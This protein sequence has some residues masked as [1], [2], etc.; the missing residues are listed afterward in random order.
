[1]SEQTAQEPTMEEILASIRRIIS[2]D[3]APAA[4]AA[5]AH[6]PEPEHAPEPEH[7]HAPAEVAPSMM[8]ETPSMEE[9]D[10]LELT[11]RWEEPA[12]VETI[13]DIE[14]APRPFEAPRPEPVYE[15]PRAPLR[16]EP[17]ADSLVSNHIADSAASSFAGLAQQIMMPRNGLM[18]ED[19][20]KEMMKPLLKQWL[21]Q[22]LDRIVQEAVRVEVERISR[23]GA[24]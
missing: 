11:D 18:L 15:A 8:D 14:A 3:E 4:E 22:N 21:D 19:V 10:V 13:G 5:P 24:G 9:D 1:M 20:V 12:P 16:E 17:A 23:R 2:E 6:T 7:H